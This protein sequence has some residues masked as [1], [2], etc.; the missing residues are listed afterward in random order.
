MYCSSDD[1]D[2]SIYAA[3]LEDGTLAVMIVNLAL[4]ETTKVIRMGDQTEVQAE[5][6]GNT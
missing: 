2:L 5:R 6:V 4:E 3:R 1:P